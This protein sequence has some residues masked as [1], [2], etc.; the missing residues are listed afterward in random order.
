MRDA[1]NQTKSDG[2]DGNPESPGESQ[3]G[4]ISA[5]QPATQDDDFSVIG[6]TPEKKDDSKNDES[7]QVEEINDVQQS[8]E[9]LTGEIS[10]ET[11]TSTEDQLLS[12]GETQDSTEVV[13]D[14]EDSPSNSTNTAGNAKE[15]EKKQ[16]AKSPQKKAAK[17]KTKAAPPPRSSPRIKEKKKET[18]LKKLSSYNS[19][20][21]NEKGRKR[22]A[23]RNL[24]ADFEEKDPKKAKTDSKGKKGQPAKKRGTG[25]KLNISLKNA[26]TTSSKKK[27]K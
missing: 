2:E 26:P 21:S 4:T 3:H 12:P 20:P 15:E 5:D 11:L 9:T 19:P 6:S 27:G 13:K 25:K 8:Q 24:S 23:A 7:P 1:E 14:T 22:P 17:G 10:Q 18:E 16:K